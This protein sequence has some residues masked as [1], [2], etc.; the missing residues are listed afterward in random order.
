MQR[1]WR[2]A[3]YWLAP[4]GFLNLFSYGVQD[5][6]TGFGTT[7]SELSS[8]ML[9]LNQGN[10]PQASLLGAFFQLIFSLPK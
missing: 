6:Q 1:P 3:A 10:V 4:H 9:I 2:I 8:P 7:H 5:R